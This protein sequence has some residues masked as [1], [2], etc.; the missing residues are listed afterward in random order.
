MRCC[1]HGISVCEKCEETRIAETALKI[2]SEVA[3][4]REA[5][6]N[7]RWIAAFLGLVIGVLGT[8]GALS[9]LGWLR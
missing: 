2:A 6:D 8:H 4:V 7:W 5:Q 1:L 3:S 9:L